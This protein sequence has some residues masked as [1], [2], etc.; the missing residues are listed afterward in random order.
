MAEEIG[1]QQAFLEAGGDRV[2]E[3]VPYPLTHE[4][5]R[6]MAEKREHLLRIQFDDERF[7]DDDEAILAGLS[8][9]H[10]DEC[11]IRFR[12][13]CGMWHAWERGLRQ[14][15][16]DQELTAH[17]LINADPTYVSVAGRTVAVHP[18]S[19][20]K[21]IHMSRYDRRRR[22]LA[23]VLEQC[24]RM[25]AE[26]RWSRWRR[27]RTERFL[28]RTENEWLHQTRGL[29]ANALGPSGRAYLPDEAPAYWEE[30]TAEDERHILEALLE[31]TRKFRTLPPS[32]RNDVKT[33]KG[34]DWGFDTVLAIWEPR[35]NLLPAQLNDVPLTS[36]LTWVMAGADEGAALAEIEK[37]FAA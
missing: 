11:F 31:P 23:D 5:I 22:Q 32:A 17:L 36:F 28:E 13:L 3:A 12:H 7:S 14:T 1:F 8:V 20:S 30:I 24:T 16:T 2:V 18:P 19:R 25:L 15:N 4:H 26:R 27:K 33:R 9:D 29:L 35:L 6:R 10:P 37:A 21:M 34:R